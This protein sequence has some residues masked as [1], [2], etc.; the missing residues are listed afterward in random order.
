MPSDCYTEKFIEKA[1]C[2][3]V[4]SEFVLDKKK[5]NIHKTKK[6]YVILIL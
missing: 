2:G 6:T 1:I 4:G 5:F 3:E